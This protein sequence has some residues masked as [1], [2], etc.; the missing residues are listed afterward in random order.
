M[1]WRLVYSIAYFADTTFVTISRIL[2]KWGV[3]GSPCMINL[4]NYT[5]LSWRICHN[6]ALGIYE[7]LW[8]LTTGK[9]SIYS[10]KNEVLDRTLHLQ[11]W[12]SCREFRT[13]YAILYQLI[14]QYKWH[15]GA[16]RMEIKFPGPWKSTGIDL[17][18][19]EFPY[20]PQDKS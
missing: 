14:N 2:M 19:T 1:P 12:I 17:H 20:S 10:A 3:F 11:V 6:M 16:I 4:T 9:A 7:D 15:G 18:L 13:R 5:H 8:K